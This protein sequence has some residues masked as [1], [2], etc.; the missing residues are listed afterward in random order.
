MSRR[1]MTLIELMLAMSLFT[2]LL[3]TIGGLLISGV[4]ANDAWGKTL[5]PYEQLER[6]LNR[7]SRDCESARLLFMLPAAGDDSHFEF[8][9]VEQTNAAEPAAEWRRIVYRLVPQEGE[10]VL[11]REA[12]V[13][14]KDVKEPVTQEALARLKSGHFSFAQ[15]DAQHAMQW[16]SAWDGTKYGVPQLV[17]FTSTFAQGASAEEEAV[18]R[19]IRNPAG[20]LPI[21]EPS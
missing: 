16:V 17:K 4:R 18:T 21:A 9:R 5:E 13:L 19:V 20:N 11:M 12:Y 2:A 7:L 15:L 3:I 1:A 6:G 8:A 14:G 10:V